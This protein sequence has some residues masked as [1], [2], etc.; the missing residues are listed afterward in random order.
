MRK[1]QITRGSELVT[2]VIF[3]ANRDSSAESQRT[4][5]D[6]QGGFGH[7]PTKKVG[8]RRNDSGSPDVLIRGR[9][10]V[11]VESSLGQ[12]LDVCPA[13]ASVGASGLPCRHTGGPAVGVR[14]GCGVVT[15]VTIPYP[16]L[17]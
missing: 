9:T 17:P 15:L 6:T 8:N 4:P 10:A 14:P 5:D 7:A 11:T 13:N 3:P 16:N 12:G 1:R 2:C